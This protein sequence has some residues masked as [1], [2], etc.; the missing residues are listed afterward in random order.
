MGE[1]ETFD[2]LTYIS[3]RF[4]N[5]PICMFSGSHGERPPVKL[6]APK[7][8]PLVDSSCP[9]QTGL[10]GRQIFRLGDVYPSS[11]DRVR[12]AR[13]ANAIRPIKRLGSHEV[14]YEKMAAYLCWARVLPHRLRATSFPAVAS[15]FQSWLRMPNNQRG[16]AMSS[17]LKMH[18]SS[19]RMLL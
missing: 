4:Y 2:D 16:G 14:C 1:T 5:F 18:R 3:S 12:F 8:F 6:L 7:S 13:N 9:A 15:S 17:R 19:L 10:M 11:K